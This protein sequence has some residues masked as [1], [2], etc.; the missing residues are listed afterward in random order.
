[1][2]SAAASGALVA[3]ADFAAVPGAEAAVRFTGAGAKLPDLAGKLYVVTG[4]NSGIGLDGAAKLWSAGADVVLACRTEQKALDAKAAVLA[5]APRGGSGRLTA[6]ACDLADLAS[7]RAFAEDM[8][9]AERTAT[10]DALCLNAGAQFTGAPE[11]LRT[12]DGFEL[13]VG[14]NHLGHFLLAGLLLPAVE[15]ADAGRVV[16]TASEVH[17]PASPGGSVGLG[18][19]LGDLSGLEQ[20]PGFVMVDGGA[21]DADKAYKDSKLCNVLFARELQRRL[22]AKGSRATCNSFGPGLITRTG[23][24]RY[25]NPVF[26]K[27]FDFATNELFG[28]AET[29]SGGG[30]CLAFMMADPSLDGKGGLYYNNDLDGFRGHDFHVDDPSAEA[31]DDAEAAKLWALSAKLVGLDA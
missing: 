1:M 8:L 16:V 28:V 10:I 20:G 21:W 30:D 4:A 7:V 17:D 25:Q 14:A 18:A 29:V 3:S 5:A 31:L 22:A 11:P 26:V 13:T 12:K 23:F 15:R 2:G 9:A 24:F 19:T 6:K 27:L